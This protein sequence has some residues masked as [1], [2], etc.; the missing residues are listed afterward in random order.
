MRFQRLE[1]LI[2]LMKLNQLNDKTVLICGIGG[3][4]SYATEA[5]AR[6]GIGHLILVDNDIVDITN[7]N[8]QIIA[9][10]STLNQPKVS[11]MMKRILD[12]NPNAIVTPLQLYIDET[13]IDSLLNQKIDFVIDAIDSVPSKCL[14]IAACAQRNIPIIASMGFALK[15]HPEKIELTTLDKTEMDPLAK[16][17]RY[18]LRKAGINLKIPVV[19]SKEQPLKSHIDSVK[20]G[21]TAFVPPSAG[22]ML[23]SYVINQFLM[24]EN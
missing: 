16:E 21:S 9:L 15:L 7:I 8:R 5:L 23:A 4:G 17:I 11:V 19:Y 24:E 10:E 2:G 22:L 12:I 1:A 20:L 13:S 14:L 6:S 18:R 3:V